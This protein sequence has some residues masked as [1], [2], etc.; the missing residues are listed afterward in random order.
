[1][2]SSPISAEASPES[3]APGHTAQAKCLA[4]QERLQ[5]RWRGK[6]SGGGTTVTIDGDSLRFESSPEKWWQTTFTIA[7]VPLEGGEDG[8]ESQKQIHATIERY[9]DEGQEHVG[10]IVVALYRLEGDTLTLGVVDD[11]ERVPDDL[12]GDWDWIMDIWEL[13]KAPGAQS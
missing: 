5:G 12:V 4:D 9:G 11:Y 3:E 6:G 10:K 13:H 1:M 2:E 8:G 7:T